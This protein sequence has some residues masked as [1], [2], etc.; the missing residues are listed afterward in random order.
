M[1]FGN[2]AFQSCPDNFLGRSGNHVKAKF[3]TVD[4]TCRK[5]ESSECYALNE[6]AFRLHEGA[7]S[8]HTC[9]QDRATEDTQAHRLLNK[10][11]AGES[12]TFP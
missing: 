10:V 12:A 1:I 8:A 6:H 4:T 3:V 9:I 11:N 7:P 2:D 5:S